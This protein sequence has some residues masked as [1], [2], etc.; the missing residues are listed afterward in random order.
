MTEAAAGR[1][2]VIEPVTRV[3]GHGKVT[4]HLDESGRVRDSF[5]HIV[6]FRG[7]ERFVQ[8]RPYWE[9][10]SLV[11]RLCGIC[12]VSHHLAAAKAV[13]QL[14]GL[15]PRDLSPTATLVRRLL[16]YG[17]V[18]QS[19]ALHFFYL[20]SPDLLF[21]PDAPVEKRSVAAVAFEHKDLARKGILM[22]K[23]GQEV[24]RALAGKRIHG[25][26]AVPGGIH[27]SLA[28]EDRER[29]LSESDLPGIDAMIAWS[30]EAVAFVKDYHEKHAAWLDTF[31]AYPSGHLGLV[32]ADGSLDLYDGRL[33]AIDAEGRRTLDDVADTDYLAHFNEGVE[34]WTFLKF[35][36]LKA[37][38][39]ERGWNRVGPLARLNVCDRIGTPLA[40]AERAEYFARTGGKPNHRTMHFHWARLIETLHCAEVMKEL[41]LDDEISG[42]DLVR[43]GERRPE[44]IG[45]VEA[46]RG[47]LIHHYRADEKGRVTR[48]N[49]I[50]ST[51]HNNEPMNRAVRWVADHVLSGKR[52]LTDTLLNQ[53]EIAVR[54]YD[55][56]LSC[57]THAIGDM[58]LAVTLY[59]H[60]GEVLDE[61]RKDA[62]PRAR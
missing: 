43:K 19:H 50:V 2:V 28:P 9:V 39:R 49:L 7:F 33:R 57:A 41:L 22:R 5:F 45:V 58:P 1:K 29:F 26:A 31:A 56:C 40:E 36:Y 38:G 44:G 46:P 15:D 18:F 4:I 35:P 53:V 12:P 54:A 51:T 42:A 16:H 11:Q 60:R 34:S 23:F 25:V 59:D 3:E 55:P 21:G 13:D 17:Q 8:G 48:C 14:S 20:A 10:P 6:E 27:K 37:L 32:A 24:I 47:T 61:R 30:R 52:E 62:G